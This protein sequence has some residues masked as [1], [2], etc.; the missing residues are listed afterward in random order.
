VTDAEMPGDPVPKALPQLKQCAACRRCLDACKT[1]AFGRKV[2]VKVDGATERF[3]LH[4][5]V[6]CD[7][8]KRYS[9]VGEEGVNFVGWKMNLPVPDKIDAQALDAGL[10]QQPPIPKYRP[11]NFEACVLACPLVRS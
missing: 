2:S 5:I 3:H 10:R 9:L 4:D 11:C 6:R 1:R 7:W 8:A